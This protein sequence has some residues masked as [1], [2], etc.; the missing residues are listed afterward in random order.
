MCIFMTLRNRGLC[1]QV[2]ISQLCIKSIYLSPQE[3]NTMSEQDG[4]SGQER[5]DGRGSECGERRIMLIRNQESHLHVVDLDSMETRMCLA[6]V[7]VS[8][9]EWNRSKGLVESAVWWLAE[10][11]LRKEAVQGP[12]AGSWSNVIILVDLRTPLLC[13]VWASLWIFS[14]MY[15]QGNISHCALILGLMISECMFWLWDGSTCL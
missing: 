8:V 6:S 2:H 15:I 13:D 11:S 10:V 7:T 4:I 12:G 3:S 14:R 9:G 1:V 5:W